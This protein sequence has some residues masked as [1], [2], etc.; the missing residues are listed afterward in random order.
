MVGREL[1]SHGGQGQTQLTP[2][3]QLRA[4]SRT[5]R[6]FR[7]SRTERPF[8][9]PTRTHKKN[10]T[11]DGYKQFNLAHRR[12]DAAHDVSTAKLISNHQKLE[13]CNTSTTHVLA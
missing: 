13:I 1:A 3:Q 2:R 10:K 6:I 5:Q 4:F 7:V 12:E 11:N 8:D 9:R